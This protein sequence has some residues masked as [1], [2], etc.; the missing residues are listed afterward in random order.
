MIQHTHANLARTRCFLV[1]SMTV[2]VAGLPLSS[3]WLPVAM[4]QLYISLAFGLALV[5]MSIGA[6]SARNQPLLM[7]I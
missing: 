6:S 4:G 5:V 1:H 7:K 3:N 2:H